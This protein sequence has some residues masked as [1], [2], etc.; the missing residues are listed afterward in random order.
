MRRSTKPIGM[1]PLLAPTVTATKTDS[2]PDPDNNNQADPGET[3]TYTVNIGASGEDATGVTFTDTVDP[4]TTFVPGSL[5][6]TP[7]AVD[8]SY[9]A[10]A[11]LE[12]QYRRPAACFGRNDFGRPGGDSQRLRATSAPPTASVNGELGDEPNGGRHR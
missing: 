7:V 4:N 5:T 8:D 9:S 6:A 1:T 12:S 2:F 3:L 10:W 11:M